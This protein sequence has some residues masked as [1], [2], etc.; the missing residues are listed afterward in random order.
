MDASGNSNTVGSLYSITNQPSMRTGSS[1]IVTVSSGVEFGS[2]IRSTPPVYPPA[3][4]AA[5]VSGT[6]VLS[7]IISERGTIKNLRVMSGPVLLQESAVDA[8]RTWRYKP[9]KLNNQPTEIE[10]TINVTFSLGN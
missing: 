9:P 7:A 3:A 6:V 8:V 2:L 10:T 5:R 4:R 1:K